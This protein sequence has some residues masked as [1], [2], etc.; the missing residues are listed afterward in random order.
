[1]KKK[2][3]ITV[4]GLGYVGL[5]LALE[6][7]KKYPTIGF[8]I[9][10]LRI[11]QLKEKKDINKEF[12]KKDITFS[13]ELKFKDHIDNKNNSD[14]YIITVPTPITKSNKPDLSLVINACKLVGRNIKKNN[15]VV[16][17]S[18]VYPGATEEVFV[19][20]IEKISGY[21]G[22]KDFFYGY[23]PERINPGDKN[24]KLTN[25]LKIVSGS[26]KK[27]A[28]YLK[29]LYGSIIKKGIYLTEN[30]KIA[31]AAKVIENTQRDLN[32]ALVN[33]LALIFDKLNLNTN[34]VLDAANTKWN[35]INF[36]PGLVG[37]HCIGVDPYY[38]TYKAKQ[39]GYNSKVILA[40][41][42]VNNYL[43]IHV[44]KKVIKKL[45]V[46]FKIKYFR[47]LIMGYT[48]KENCSDIRNTKV[49][50]IIKEL[51]KHNLKVDVY[52]DNVN[53]S[54]FKKYHN[55]K[56]IDK[57][58]DVKKNYYHSIIIAV[59]HDSF[60][61]IKFDDIKSF[62]VRNALIYDLKNFFPKTEKILKL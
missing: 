21:K 23:S 3:K 37:G 45:N 14:I 2:I 11:K 62:G 48:F 10:K 9:N 49:Q 53:T 34:K 60:K 15:I 56:I 55:K 28:N 12:T 16:F 18:T 46:K 61:K 4:I 19:P 32:I 29:R 41:R 13:K 59:K 40:G 20:V 26:N 31:E 52:D 25:I 7:G 54:E 35:F 30:I 47:V 17:E 43:P 51:N 57:L 27:T 33:E 24:K 8:D 50:D 36:R 42:K 22:N 39:A 44:A 38:L 1:M 58:K 5:P 6:F